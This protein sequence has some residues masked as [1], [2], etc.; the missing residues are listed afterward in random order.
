MMLIVVTTKIEAPELRAVPKRSVRQFR[1]SSPNISRIACCD[2]GYDR[3]SGRP[4]V[5][6]RQAP[7]DY[8]WDKKDKLTMRRTG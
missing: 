5:F 6:L 4:R 8:A 7:R 3:P 1:P 2:R